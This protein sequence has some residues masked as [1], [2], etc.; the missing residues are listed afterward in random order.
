[1][2]TKALLLHVTSS[3][4]IQHNKHFITA[5]PFTIATNKGDA[6]IAEVD[7]CIFTSLMAIN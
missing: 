6:Q 2:E 4:K 1:M 7:E 3:E 5:L